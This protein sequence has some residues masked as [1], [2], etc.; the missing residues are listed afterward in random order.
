MGGA[1]V[2]EVKKVNMVGVLSM[3]VGIWNMQKC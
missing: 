1:E 2:D 3:Q